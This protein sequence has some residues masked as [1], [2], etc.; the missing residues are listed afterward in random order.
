MNARP[1][2]H[3]LARELAERAGRALLRLRQAVAGA[4]EAAT[5]GARGDAVAHRLLMDALQQARPDDAVLS[6]EE[7]PDAAQEAARL[8]ARRVWIIDPLDGTREYAEC[9]GHDAQGRPLFERS[10]WAVHVA[11]A[12]DGEPLV[13]AVALPAQQVCYGT[14]AEL[15]R[16]TP[17]QPGER[18]R[19]AISR[20]R[21]APQVLELIQ[22]LGAE[23][24]PMGSA[25]AKAMA[26][27]RGEVHAYL[28]AG[29][30]R[31]WDSCAPVAVV[32]AA[33]LHAS[34]IDGGELR[35]NQR[36]AWTD[37]LWICGSVPPDFLG[38]P[39][40]HTRPPTAHSVRR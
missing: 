37:D 39:I 19:I 36:Q 26:V 16:P 32:R 35:F 9:T 29:G 7:Q 21:A 30:L 11:L 4:A 34:R 18:L 17:P 5:L 23:A 20:S 40:P 6:E 12:V 10:D 38:L 24:V 13:G 33:G 28:H 15:P 14:G 27:L 22:R 8:A 1:E 25:G 31:E 3:A 2:D